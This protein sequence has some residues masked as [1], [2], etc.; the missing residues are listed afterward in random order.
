MRIR[1]FDHDRK[2]QSC[3]G[4]VAKGLVLESVKGRFASI[5]RA[6]ERNCPKSPNVHGAEATEV[7][8]TNLRSPVLLLKDSKMETPDV[9]LAP[10]RTVSEGIFSET[11]LQPIA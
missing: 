4:M 9:T 1:Y 7:D 3:Q 10:F 2:Q 6:A 8:E 11:H 5:H